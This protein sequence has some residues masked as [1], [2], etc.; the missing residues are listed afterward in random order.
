MLPVAMSVTQ[1]CC[2]R[3]CL[4]WGQGTS[5]SQGYCDSF[6]LVAPSDT[7]RE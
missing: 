1:L 2:L 3:P 7:L 5:K 6:L 4:G